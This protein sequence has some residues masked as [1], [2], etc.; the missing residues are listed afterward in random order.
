MHVRL[1]GLTEPHPY[2]EKP[3]FDINKVRVW[4]G[5]MRGGHEGEGKSEGGRGRGHGIIHAKIMMY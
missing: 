5:C 2:K 4:E 1:Q 3:M